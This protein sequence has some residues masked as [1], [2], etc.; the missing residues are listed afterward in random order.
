MQI[1]CG[2]VSEKKNYER[3]KSGFSFNAQTQLYD[4]ILQ[5]IN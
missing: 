5:N 3:R 2:V 4:V 1:L